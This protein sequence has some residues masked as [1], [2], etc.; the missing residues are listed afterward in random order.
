MIKITLYV[1]NTIVLHHYFMTYGFQTTWSTHAQTHTHVNTH[2]QSYTGFVK[3]N[4]NNAAIQ[5]LSV[6]RYYTWNK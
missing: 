1:D 5:V 6:Y 3:Y 2:M 4:N